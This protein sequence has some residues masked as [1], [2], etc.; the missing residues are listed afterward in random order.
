MNKCYSL[1][2]DPLVA[3]DTKAHE[4]WVEASVEA[5]YDRSDDYPYGVVPSDDTE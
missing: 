2:E 4:L 1:L 5:L 3:A